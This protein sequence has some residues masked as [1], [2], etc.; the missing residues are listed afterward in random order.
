[1]RKDGHHFRRQAPL[2][3]YFL[4]FV[5][6]SCRLVIEVDGSQH[7]AESQ[8][9][10]DALRDKVLSREGFS[11]L[12]FQAIDVM[13]NLEGV[14]IVIRQALATPTPALPTRGMEK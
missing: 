3:G 6:Y 11:T 4:D 9:E 5:C 7:G 12:R 1:L 10:H 14:A 13:Q 8:A 2:R